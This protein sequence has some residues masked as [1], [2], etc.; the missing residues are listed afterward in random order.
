[1]A[2][3]VDRLSE[4]I[5]EV[6]LAF[7]EGRSEMEHGRIESARDHF[8]RA[9]DLLLSEPGGARSQPRLRAEFDSLL[10]RISALE[11]I[12]LREGDG[13]TEAKSVPAALDDLLEAA[14]FERPTP[15][16]TTEE[17]VIADLARTPHDLPIPINDKVL[18]Y[19][20]L[21]QARLKDF[22]QAGLER[23]LQYLPMIQRVFREEGIPIDLSYV[24][25][26]E[27]AFKVNAQS[28][29]SARG[30]WQFML[31][32]GREM[33][34]QQ[35]WFLDERADPEKATRAA[36]QY[37]KS[38]NNFFGDWH[39]ALASYNAGP[40]RVQRAMR[41]SRRSDYWELTATSR[42][43]PRE[44][45]EYVPMILAA[46]IIARNPTLYGFELGAPTPISYERVTVPGALDLRIIAEWASV[47]V[48]QIQA[49]NPELRRT[50]TPTGS[51][52]LKVPYGT[53][54]T[55]QAKLDAADPGLFV[56]FDFHTVKRGETAAGIARKYGIKTADLLAANQ[57][58]TTRL[59][60]NTVLT[61][62]SRATSALPAAPKPTASAPSSS[63]STALTYRVRR[64]DT[65]FSIA[66]QFDT[67]VA[68]LKQ[69]N[70]LSSDRINPGDRLTVR[71]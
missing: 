9:I 10:D 33:G 71:R 38:L 6:E 48:E 12:A 39:L 64:G 5:V 68:T 20:E 35:N 1:M 45:R 62:P 19:V 65:L 57:L 43:L 13:F 18:S 2:V 40:G 36:A 17:T 46:V 24:P 66:R 27:S 49:L 61:I 31:G 52:E 25:L 67:T 55:V 47:E 26:V 44:T 8:D 3:V 4:L 34:L 59:R 50:T 7:S 15:A 63:A 53:A 21:F 54:A 11:V 56:K 29:A 28:R 22:M 41:L 58:K 32:T 60:A 30:M 14:M 16:E 70:S 23:G 69:L 51:H 37:L 42:Y